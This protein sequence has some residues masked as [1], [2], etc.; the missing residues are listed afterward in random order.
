MTRVERCELG[1]IYL[2]TFGA[3]KHSYKA[4]RRTYLSQRDLQAHVNHRHSSKTGSASV[5]AIPSSGPPPT[6]AAVIRPPQAQRQASRHHHGQSTS[7]LSGHQIGSQSNV[8]ASIP[9]HR[10][11]PAATTTRGNLITIQLQGDHSAAGE[12]AAQQGARR[13][14]QR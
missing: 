4:C 9:V 3:P 1:Q 11:P 14:N 13:T 6:S 10:P 8:A 2:C 5:T 12:S 7:A